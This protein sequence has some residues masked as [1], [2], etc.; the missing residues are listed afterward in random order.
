MGILENGQWLFA[1]QGRQKCFQVNYIK[2]GQQWPHTIHHLTRPN[3]NNV[4][5]HLLTEVPYRMWE[6][7]LEP[8]R[9]LQLAP[10]AQG[11][12]LAILVPLKLNK[13]ERNLKKKKKNDWVIW[14]WKRSKP[15]GVTV[16]VWPSAPKW[17]ETA[18]RV[19]I[20]LI[21]SEQTP[22]QHITDLDQS[23]LWRTQMI[24]KS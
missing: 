17:S 23:H 10:K 21:N 15:L 6:R 14:L 20:P 16:E 18:V 8:L 1:T 19:I 5:T 2:T 9:W 4:F 13:A 12:F 24:N 22:H 11:C 7:N 3:F